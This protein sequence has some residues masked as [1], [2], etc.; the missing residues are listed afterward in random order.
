MPIYGGK[1]R[2]GGVHYELRAVDNLERQDE[3]PRYRI[4][5]TTPNEYGRIW[6]GNDERDKFR[7]AAVDSLI[8][9]GGQWLERPA[10]G[11]RELQGYSLPELA[12]ECLRKS[13][14]Q[15]SGDIFEIVT[16]AI[17]TP[18]LPAILSATANKFL[19]I[20][21]DMA[22]E[23]WQT[24]CGTGSIPDFKN[25]TIN[26]LSET[27]D[28]VVIPE[29]KPYAYGQVSD[30]KETTAILTYGL[31]FAITRQ[32][33]IN[34][35]LSALTQIP[36]KHGEA[37]AR[38]VGDLAY[39]V[40]TTN[41]AMGD[42]LALFIAAHGNMVTGLPNTVAILAAA[43]TLMKK[44]KDIGGKQ[45]LNIRPQY[46]IAPVALEGVMEQ[47]FNSGQVGGATATDAGR[48]MLGNPY[49]GSVF[50]RAYDARLDDTSAVQWYMAGPK[51]RTVNV[52][53]LN[54][55]E[56]PY[57]EMKLG[58]SVDGIEYKVRL[59]AVAKAVDWRGLV[60]SS[61]A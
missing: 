14:Q 52:Y 56:T 30:L 59:D 48:A 46:F 38:K 27:D 16:R 54:G 47:F 23:T 49:A 26:R 51:G 32:A 7:A 4:F 3:S 61:G 43:I 18:D 9:R 33:I 8:L 40:L 20:G 55:V 21:Y 29:G 58:W 50:T 36:Q 17:E 24:W 2:S 35:D 1:Q 12:R 28:L 6:V 53:F 22:E 34:D 5:S 57:L 44:Q 11:A 10:P 25:A 45:R 31:M 42:G 15:I 37:A 13:G 39:S 19:F 41:A 60:Y